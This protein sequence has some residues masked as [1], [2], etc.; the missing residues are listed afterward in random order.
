MFPD[1]GG[2]DCNMFMTQRDMPNKLVLRS[3]WNPGDLYMLVECFARHDPLNPTAILS[4]ERYSASFAE[5]TPEK[6]VS[7][8]NA[9]AIQDLSGSS[10]YLRQQPFTGERALPLGWDGMEVTVP[11]LS[12][13]RLATHARID[14]EG[15]MGYEAKHSRE[16]L[17]VKNR[18]VLI[19]DKTRFDDHFRA[20]LGPVWNTQ[21][22]GPSRGEHWLNTWF[23]G[24]F[25]QGVQMYESP[26]WDLLIYY[27]PQVEA[28]VVVSEAPIDTPFKTQLVSTQY[29][30]EGDVTPG[31]QLQFTTLL[32]PHAPM[33]DAT[34]LVEGIRVLVDQPGTVALEVAG[35]N[36]SELVLLNP[37]G[38]RLEMTL[39]DGT[40]VVTDSKAAYVNRST[41]GKELILA[42][43][44]TH[45]AIGGRNLVQSDKRQ[46]W[47]QQNSPE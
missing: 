4:L 30:W 46:D 29:R 14:V 5:M 9:V 17:F 38:A 20:A 33:R 7:R 25:F 26:A 22:I 6:F 2:V 39:A 8:E 28:K 31:G 23:Q 44:I 21:R 43:Q 41:R 19:R 35:N 18:F 34:L 24:H 13:H 15:Y 11:V 45:L 12:D 37:T 3:G 32:L 10:R 27:A 36:R 1:A 42:R 47:E 16:I 40:P